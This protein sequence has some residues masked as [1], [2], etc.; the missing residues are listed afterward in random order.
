LKSGHFVFLGN[1]IIIDI[2]KTKFS[3]HGKGK[4]VEGK[5]ATAVTACHI[6]CLGKEDQTTDRDSLNQKDKHGGLLTNPPP[7][8]GLRSQQYSWT[9]A[10]VSF[11]F[12]VLHNNTDYDDFTDK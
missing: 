4:K 12:A 7:I 10:L 9:Q 3:A 1:Q 11:M 6:P 2:K 8:R 5:K